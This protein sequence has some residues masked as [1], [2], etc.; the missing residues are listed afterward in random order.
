[1]R[2]PDLKWMMTEVR[3]DW[4]PATL[5]HLDR[6][7]EENRDSLPA[8]RRPSEYWQ[9]NCLA[10]VSFMHKS[11]VDQRDEIGVDTLDF[12]RDYPHTESTWPNTIEYYKILF[13]G[14]PQDDVRKILGENAIRFFGLDRDA[15]VKVAERI[16]PDLDEITDPDA[17]VDPAL[18]EHL[19]N[20]CGVL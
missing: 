6:V 9:S 20:R 16:G 12:G 8:K 19:S 1:D 13:A 14:V 11:E 4:I 10:G 5:E 18:V 15:L 2:H 17:V 3:A 7:Y